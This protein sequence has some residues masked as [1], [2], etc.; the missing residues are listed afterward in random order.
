MNSVDDSIIRFGDFEADL[1]TQELRR[2]GIKLRLPNQSF[3]VLS[4]LLE[5]PGELVT[6]EQ[7]RE[8]LWP[9]DTFV[10]YDQGLN[11]AVNRLREALG[12]S[13]DRPRFIE[14]LPR[15]GYRFLGTTEIPSRNSETEI[16][17]QA[18]NGLAPVASATVVSA[19]DVKPGRAIPEPAESSPR[20]RTGRIL[21]VSS[22]AILVVGFLLYALQ[23]RETPNGIAAAKVIPVTTLPG[24]E[25]SPT[26]SPD[27]SQIAFAWNG[28]SNSV[29]GFDLYVKTVGSERMLRL[30]NKP[31]HRISAAWSPDGS[32][33]VF[34][35][36]SD[37]GSGVFLIPALGGPERKLLDAN[38][39]DDPFG[40]ISWSPDG[41]TLAL[42]P[43]SASGSHIVLLSLDTLQTRTLEGAPR[44]WNAGT[45]VFSPDGR[46]LAF[47]C[48]SSVAVYSI[49]VVRLESGSSRRLDSMMGFPRGLA[50]SAD[51]NSLIL[52]NDPGDGG[53]LW[54]LSIDGKLSPLPFGEQASS[55]VIAARG[56]R[57][58]YARTAKTIN[59]WRIDLAA[60][61]P[62]RTA[63]K[64][65]SSTRIQQDPQY[66]P[67][68]K[69]IVFESNRSGAQEIWLADA[70]GSNLVQLTSFKGPL[71]GAPQWCSDS[72]RIS[73]DSRAS[74]T[75]AIYVEDIY[76]RLPRRVQTDQQNLALPSWS[77]D[78]RWLFA[79][80]GHD[81]L[82]RIGSQGGNAALVS[83]NGTYYSVARG[84]RVFFNVRGTQ[85][86]VEIRSR[87][88]TGGSEEPL[89]NM[90]SVSYSESW[91]AA[92]KGIYYTDSR[93]GAT[94]LM[95]YDFGRKTTNEVS[96]LP[97]MPTSAGGLGMSVS[98]DGRWLVYTQTDSQDSDLMLVEN[99]R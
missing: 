66:S 89:Q 19:A 23:H 16:L 21:A 12:D 58:A 81:N 47:M 52:V 57:I 79:S 26:F 17:T 31:A 7:L 61:D 11:A 30:T 93:S 75:A 49:D 76:E 68:G 94:S 54:Q 46:D 24:Q 60:R 72:R 29:S 40:G 10:E 71:T 86:K 14:T 62:E 91:T 33:I 63:T 8:R 28:Q 74:G 22:V 45:P 92:A 27:G 53:E 20:R 95:F 65:I 1:R 84:D 32:Q 98:P 4:M 39:D 13:A 80:D 41:K 69:K 38:F 56:K 88:I 77:Q 6:R 50:W 85:G 42:S 25:T 36:L 83:S 78:C 44:C 70:D 99:F 3:V 82:Y 43:Q 59:I 15:R 67:D 34:S 37:E 48:T 87:P 90:P 51:G 2:R 35:R 55:P 9:G 64:L 5:R 18:A 96:K 73:F 97:Q